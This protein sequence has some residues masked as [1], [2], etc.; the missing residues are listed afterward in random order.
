MGQ[1]GY[2]YIPSACE[3]TNCPVSFV[4]HGCQQG[5][6]SVGTKFVEFAGFN[7]YAEANGV[8]LLYP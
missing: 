7:N 4:F 6:E 3:K 1:V 8:V 5:V 2:A